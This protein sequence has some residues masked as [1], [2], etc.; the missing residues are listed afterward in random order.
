[1][2]INYSKILDIISIILLFFIIFNIYYSCHFK[3][4]SFENFTVIKENKE[5]FSKYENEIYTGLKDGTLTTNDIPRLIQ[6]GSLTKDSL[7]KIISRLS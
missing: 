5:N 3:K 4:N 6:G 1:M 2:K 7:E